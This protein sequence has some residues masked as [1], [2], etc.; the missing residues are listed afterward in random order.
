MAKKHMMLDFEAKR[1][2]IDAGVH[3][4]R[5]DPTMSLVEIVKRTHAQ[6]KPEQ[7]GPVLSVTQAKWFKE[8]IKEGLAVPA[9]SAVTPAISRESDEVLAGRV[10]TDLL[11]SELLRRLLAPS[12]AGM[13]QRITSALR[14]YMHGLVQSIRFQPVQAVVNGAITTKRKILVIGLLPEQQRQ[15][16]KDFGSEFELRFFKDENLKL[17]RTRAESCEFSILMTRFISHAHQD[18][19]KGL[20]VEYVNG[21]VSDLEKFLL[22]LV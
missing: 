8:G 16:E 3:Y 9:V 18:A 6:L 2:Y 20:K 11:I 15:I 17:L 4:R 13:E 22:E 5:K 7:R 12:M 10:P 1:A 21:S 14:E 19:V